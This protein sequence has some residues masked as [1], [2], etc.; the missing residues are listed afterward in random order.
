MNG[1]AKVLQILKDYLLPFVQNPA[2]VGRWFDSLESS[3][4][5]RRLAISLAI[6]L[7]VGA[8][9][10]DAQ[11]MLGQILDRVDH[12]AAEGSIEFGR[13]LHEHPHRQDLYCASTIPT[14]DVGTG[15]ASVITLVK[16]IACAGF[17]FGFADTSEDKALLRKRY[18]GGSQ[19]RPLRGYETW[20]TA[21]NQIVWITCARRFFEKWRACDNEKRASE[22][23]DALGLP[24][25]PYVKNGI[26]LEYV[27]VCYP[28]GFDR[29]AHQ[30]T[31]LDAWWLDSGQWYLSYAKLDGW[32]RSQSISGT[33]ESQVERVHRA[34]P[35]EQV[36]SDYSLW[37][38][39]MASLG[40]EDP[41]R[42]ARAGLDILAGLDYNSPPGGPSVAAD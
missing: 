23:K 35:F 28:A 39:G 40:V 32:G 15:Y 14:T 26:P 3:P 19:A 34:H 29:P 16:F 33:H 10:K 11:V 5:G 1:W 31:A 12:A 2:A 17:A 20:W 38:L 6:D 13:Q 42:V 36:G 18:G 37:Y 9:R 27:A 4:D 8:Y 24:T 25:P 30:P 22:V 7:V 21:E 41:E